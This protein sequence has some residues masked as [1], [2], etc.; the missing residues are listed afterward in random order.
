MN[1]TGSFQNLRK[2]TTEKNP[3]DWINSEWY[4]EWERLAKEGSKDNPKPDGYWC[5]DNTTQQYK[6]INYE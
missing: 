5:Y 1:F 6:Y 4:K 3:N 2:V